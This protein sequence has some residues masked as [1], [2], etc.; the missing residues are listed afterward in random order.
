MK[1]FAIICFLLISSDM[2]GQNKD[3]IGS[4]RNYNGCWLSFN[5]DST[6]NHK[7]RFS[8]LGTYAS[9]T[10]TIINDT[11]YLKPIPK[12]KRLITPNGEYLTLSVSPDKKSIIETREPLTFPF[13][14][15]S[16][17]PHKLYF[18]K[19]KLYEIDENG[20]IITRKIRGYKNKKLP[21]YYEKSK[22]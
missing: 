2:F 12:E 20:K 3:I 17:V 18:K 1:L 13:E 19:G 22:E 14:S 8:I 5:A 6:F 4:Y 11:I 16:Y 15:D 21:S 9:G 10:W 7:Y